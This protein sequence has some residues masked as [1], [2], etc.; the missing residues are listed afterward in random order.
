MKKKILIGIAILIIF[1][2][3]LCILWKNGIILVNNPEEY[4][5]TIKGVD[6]SSY[7]GEIDW[8]I[9]AKQNIEFAFIKATEGSSYVDENFKKNL[10]GAMKTDLLVGAYHFFSYD[11]TG[12][13][14]AN[15]FIKNVPKQ[16]NML[17]PVIDIEFYG[18]KYKNIPDISTTQKELT[19]MLERLEEY[20][21]KKPIIYATNKSYNLYIVDNFNDYYIWIRDIFKLPKLKDNREWTFWQYTDKAVLNGYKGKEDKIDINVFNGSIDE[22]KKMTSIS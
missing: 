20:Y 10:E 14:Q 12:E 8:N 6:V 7:Q 21:E 22:L 11:S 17:P 2:I 3:I 4:G 19:V 1:A 9:L 5:Y 15:N 18:D 13:A 16:N